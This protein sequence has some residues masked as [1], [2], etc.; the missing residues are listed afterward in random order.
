MKIILIITA[1]LMLQGCSGGIMTAE[2]IAK[3]V[4]SCEDAGLV[5]VAVRSG[6][7]PIKP[8]RNVFCHLPEDK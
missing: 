4:K 8:I 3:E 2:E 5:A 7:A 6:F 1:I